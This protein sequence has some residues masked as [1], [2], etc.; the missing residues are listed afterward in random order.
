[1]RYLKTNRSVSILF[2]LILLI[3][4]GTVVALSVAPADSPGES[5]TRLRLRVAKST[6]RSGEVTSVW[7]EFLDRDYRQVQNDGSRSVVFGIVSRRRQPGFIAKR[8]IVVP[9]G[10]WSGGTTFTAGEAGSV[11][12]TGQSEGLDADQSTLVVTRPAASWLTQ[13]MG[14]FE[15]VAYADKPSEFQFDSAEKTTSARRDGRLDFQLIWAPPPTS[16]TTVRI[17]TDPASIISYHGKSSFGVAAITLGP[18]N[19]ASSDISIISSQEARI[20]VTAT[21]DGEARQALAI[22]NFTKPV[23]E[24]IMFTE[25]PKEIPPGD[26]IISVTLEVTDKEGFPVKSGAVR[27]LSFQ[28]GSDVVPLEFNPSSVTLSPEET[29]VE[30][31][32]HLKDLKELPPG[33]EIRVG[34]LS[35]GLRSA[36]KTIAVRRQVKGVRLTGPPEVLLG[37]AGAEFNVQLIDRDGNL[38]STDR[39]RTINL[40]ATH[41]T[42]NPAPVTIPKGQSVAKVRYVASG[43]VARALINANGEGVVDGSLQVQLVMALYWL[44]IFA[45][46]GGLIGG[47]IRHISKEG[48]KLPRILPC[49][50]G[51]CWDLGLVGKLAVSIVGGLIMYLLVK[52]GFYRVIGSLPLP[53][54]LDIGTRLVA[55]FFG[56]VGGFAGIYFFDWILSKFLPGAQQQAA[57]AA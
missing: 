49:W 15:T 2:L 29:S 51:E 50:T 52:L 53:E 57:P 35:K 40:T 5:P 13:I 6:L 48:Y 25:E 19:A 22:A 16:N 4:C 17:S 37:T 34:A 18:E 8:E 28:K 47:V 9:R 10:E 38:V 45:L 56:V 14:L 7:V 44:V 24:K 26:N 55:F 12:L 3:S 11:V 36:W 31:L 27:T 20:A 42:L 54:A 33:G 1:M 23:A 32:V 21:A 39:D 30:T 46:L 41:G 43:S